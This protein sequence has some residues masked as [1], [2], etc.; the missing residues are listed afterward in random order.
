MTKVLFVC[1][2]CHREVR[3][4]CYSNPNT[5]GFFAECPHCETENE[6][7]PE[8]KKEMDEWSESEREEVS[9]AIS[10]TS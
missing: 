8:E 3:A 4:S 5:L 9:D 1:L 6:V 7:Y 2:R 10:D